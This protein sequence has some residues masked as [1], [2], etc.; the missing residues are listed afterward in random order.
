MNL[1][2]RLSVVK[3]FVWR[4]VGIEN[5]PKVFKGENIGKVF[6]CNFSPNHSDVKL[7]S[8]LTRTINLWLTYVNEVPNVGETS[9]S[10]FWAL[11]FERNWL[12]S[13]L[14]WLPLCVKCFFSFS[15]CHLSILSVYSSSELLV[16]FCFYT[17]YCF[18][19]LTMFLGLSFAHPHLF[20]SFPFFSNFRCQ[21]T[22]VFSAIEC[23][24]FT[25]VVEEIFRLRMRGNGF[26]LVVVV[27][28]TLSFNVKKH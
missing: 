10:H 27:V 23:S 13:N 11:L 4:Y 2:G 18:Y 3:R 7:Y 20:L 19:V 26:D 1:I 22:S 21:C 6:W 8:L 14:V 12:F 16:C 25:L 9:N 5:G 17:F 15:K 24:Y 28:F